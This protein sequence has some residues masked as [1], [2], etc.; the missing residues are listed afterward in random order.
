MIFVNIILLCQLYFIGEQ[1]QMHNIVSA[2]FFSTSQ[3][4]NKSLHP[5]YPPH[6]IF[7][8]YILLTNET[9]SELWIS[10]LMLKCW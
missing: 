1:K 7:E 10:Y 6:P 2:T 3:L 9:Q 8:K 4:N 5:I